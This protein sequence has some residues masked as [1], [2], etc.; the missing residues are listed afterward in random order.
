MGKQ[1]MI[2]T[3]AA[4]AAVSMAACGSA[5]AGSSSSAAVT[6]AGG[7]A[8]TIHQGTL[9]IGTNVPFSPMEF[10]G[11]DGKTI[12]GAD[13]DLAREVAKRMGLKADVKNIGWDGLIPAEKSNRFDIVVAS[14]GDFIER[15]PQIDFVDYLT[16]QAAVIVR[17]K[18]AAT[19]K[20][21]MDL[22][23]K[24]AGAT[25]GAATVTAL[26][27]FSQQCS[28]SGKPAI[29]V[30]Q[31]ASTA[32]GI[33][34]LEAGR[35][36]AENTD[37][38]VAVYTAKTKPGFAV[39]FSGVGPKILY[40]MGV[41]KSNTALR[42]QIQKALQAIMDDGTYKKILDKYGLGQYAIKK[43][44]VNAGGHKAK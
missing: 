38:P 39:A 19:I 12:T 10:F 4:I 33:T 14:I 6:A 17:S 23:G 31:F 18:D 34:A 24:K 20:N 1:L 44:T 41:N 27:Q 32:D 11:P 29:A 13:I 35:I 7:S 16:V 36:D 25:K 5:D 9:T 43:A 2:G 28:S 15:Q 22:C 30:S 21:A 40:G 37:G 42:G 26:Q 8:K 3:M